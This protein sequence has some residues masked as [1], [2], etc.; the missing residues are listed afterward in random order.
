MLRSVTSPPPAAARHPPPAVDSDGF[1]NS[2]P[3]P[4]SLAALVPRVNWAAV[5]LPAVI[6][7]SMLVLCCGM[8]LYGIVRQRQ[9]L[10]ERPLSAATVM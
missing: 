4:D 3:G 10:C 7:A 1:A 2:A 8:S 9:V 6:L 5:A